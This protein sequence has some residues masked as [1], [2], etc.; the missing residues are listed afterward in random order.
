MGHFEV[1]MGGAFWVTANN[2]YQKE[3]VL[4]IYFRLPSALFHKVPPIFARKLGDPDGG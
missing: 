3:P 4:E 2:I 1:T